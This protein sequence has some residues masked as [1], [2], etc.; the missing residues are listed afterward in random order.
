MREGS[1]I[2]VWRRKK[3][4]YSQ[5]GQKGKNL[6]TVPNRIKTPYEHEYEAGTGLN[7]HK[8]QKLGHWMTSQ[9]KIMVEDKLTS[10][11]RISRNA[12]C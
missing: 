3:Q 6:E 7:R 1:S 9:P 8:M 5:N 11:D 10:S 2:S 4:N 12:A